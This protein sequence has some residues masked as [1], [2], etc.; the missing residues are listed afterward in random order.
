MQTREIG[1]VV[2]HERCDAVGGEEQLRRIRI[3]QSPLVAGRG[4]GVTLHA[5]QIGKHHGNIF[6]EVE[7][8]HYGALSAE[9]RASM[10]F[11]WS[12]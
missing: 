2:R 11:L 4:G 7:R 5:E 3:A 10:T 9:R 1:S 12:W 6:V 8:G